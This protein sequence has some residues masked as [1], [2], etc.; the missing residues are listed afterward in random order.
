MQIAR[1]AAALV[2]VARAAGAE[3]AQRPHHEIAG[4]VG[5]A[6]PGCYTSCRKET[7]GPAFRIGYHYE[8]AP[9]LSVGG[10]V[11]HA[12]FSYA[13]SGGEP[14]RASTT[15]IAALVRLHPL[16]NPVAEPYIELGLG[17]AIEAAPAGPRGPGSTDVRF[18]GGLALGVPFRVTPAF[19]V[20]PRFGG[21][22]TAGGRIGVSC[23]VSSAGTDCDAYR[24]SHNGFLFAGIEAGLRFSPQ[25]LLRR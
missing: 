22:V 15:L 2:A 14:D 21:A 18:G 12:R 11:E 24:T 8:L 19:W 16:Q 7:P 9:P 5:A 10:E 17:P 20:G 1:F 3:P 13:L 6:W 23:V 4:A 25:D